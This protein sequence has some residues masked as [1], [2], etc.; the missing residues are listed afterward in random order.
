MMAAVYGGD[1]VW[2]HSLGFATNVFQPVSVVY[3]LIVT[4]ALFTG[5]TWFEAARDTHPTWDVWVRRIGNASFGIYLVHP[6]FVHSWLD[7]TGPSGLA[8]NPWLNTVLTAMVALSMSLLT[9][10]WLQGRTR[11]AW[12]VGKPR[13]VV[14][15][16]RS[17]DAPPSQPSTLTGS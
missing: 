16:P 2:K 1:W 6:I 7:V 5:G 17:A 14:G 15:R 10:S 3:S 4:L 9:V 13:T 8:F 11:L 12:L